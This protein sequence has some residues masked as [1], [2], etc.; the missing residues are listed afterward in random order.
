MSVS[1][2]RVFSQETIKEELLET[3]EQLLRRTTSLTIQV[4]YSGYS[5]MPELDPNHPNPQGSG[6]AR[7]KLEGFHQS[8]PSDQ[9]S[10]RQ[11]SIVVTGNIRM[12]GSSRSNSVPGNDLGIGV[13]P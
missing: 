6:L 10:A 9:V 11:L 3:Q 1:V 2:L 5:N 4:E 12:H 7:Q 8:S 13:E